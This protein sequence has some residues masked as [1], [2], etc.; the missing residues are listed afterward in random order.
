MKIETLQELPLQFI[1]NILVNEENAGWSKA[2]AENILSFLASHQNDFYYLG[3][4]AEE[5]A[6]VLVY[7][8]EDLRL[9]MIGVAKEKR[10]QGYGTELINALKKKAEDLHLAR[11]EANAASN[12][13]GFYQANGF[14]EAGEAADAGGMQFTP[15]EYLLGKEMLGK[16]VTVTV[17]H[18]YGSFHPTIADAIYPVNFGYVSAPV[19]CNDGMQDAWVIGPQEPVETFT[20][21]VAGIVYHKNG[22]SRWIVIQQ[23][24]MVNH[25]QIINLIGF[26]EQYYET[27]I[28]WAD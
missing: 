16:S 4:Y 5:L 17:D 28:I 3:L 12:A 26:E 9:I 23:G 15:V 14:E 21:V 19:A 10:N 25:E 6:G 8:P 2:G 11:V 24:M 27:K 7:R 18:P 13:L 1:E 20:G 22:D